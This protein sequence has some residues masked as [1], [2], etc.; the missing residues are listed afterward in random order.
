MWLMQTNLFTTGHTYCH[1]HCKPEPGRPACVLS[2][3]IRACSVFNGAL[4]CLE[5]AIHRRSRQLLPN[6]SKEVDLG[7]PMADCL[8]ESPVVCCFIN[9]IRSRAKIIEL[10]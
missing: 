7:H 6:T 10:N 4:E 5:L 2:T 1:N 8:V 9:L 3:V